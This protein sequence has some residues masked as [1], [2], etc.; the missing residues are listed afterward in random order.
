[1]RVRPPEIFENEM[2][3]LWKDAMERFPDPDI[4]GMD[5]KTAKAVLEED[6]RK[7]QAYIRAHMSPLMIE[8]YGF[9]CSRH[10]DEGELYD[11]DG[12]FL[13]AKNGYPIQDWEIS[14]DHRIVDASGN[15]LYYSDGEPIMAKQLSQELFEFLK[16]NWD[17]FE[18]ATEEDRWY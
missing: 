11:K 6:H 17:E 16:D 8:F 3:S 5:E 13:I 14:P 10:G 18:G 7:M 15:Q 12:R 4:E 9:Y 1:M 2:R